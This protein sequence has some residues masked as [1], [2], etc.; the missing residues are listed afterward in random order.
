MS[1]H[2]LADLLDEPIVVLDAGCRWGF[3]DEWERLGE[4]ARLYGFDPDREECERLREQYADRPWVS[5]EAVA[6]GRTAGPATLHVTREPAQSSLYAPLTSVA[7]SYPVN[8]D[9]VTERKVAL[10]LTTLDE[11]ASSRGVRRADVLKLDTQGSELDILRGGLATLR[12]LRAIQCE[13]EFNPLYEGAALFAD[14]D[15]FLR[16][17]GFELF[18]LTTMVHYRARGTRELRYPVFQQFDAARVPA[19]GFGGQLFWADAFYVRASMARPDP[20]ADWQLLLRDSLIADALGFPDLALLD[21]DAARASAPAAHTARLRDA[22]DTAVHSTWVHGAEDT[23]WVVPDHPVALAGTLFV[24]VGG[25]IIGNGWWP[26][27]AHRFGHLRWTG[28]DVEASLDLPVVVPAGTEVEI[29]VSFAMSQE[30]S[31]GLEVEVDGVSIAL[32]RLPNPQGVVLRG[33]VPDAPLG[34]R[35]STRVV[36]RTPETIATRPDGTRRCGVAVRWARFTAP[37]AGPSSEP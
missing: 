4:R 14:V 15:T 16:R 36:L 19:L 35:R 1:L 20:S 5:V 24:D 33:A 23:P 25:P 21:L 26:S 34:E 37:G 27:E 30:I 8:A 29:L 28:P 10:D 11:W 7:E 22:A 31:R 9:M 13:V 32:E 18:R 2:E 6:L 12:G 3:A 17:Q